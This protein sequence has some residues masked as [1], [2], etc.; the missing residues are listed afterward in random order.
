MCFSFP[1]SQQEAAGPSCM[2]SPPLSPESVLSPPPSV[3]STGS[4]VS[5]DPATPQKVGSVEL[6]WKQGRGEL[7]GKTLGIVLCGVC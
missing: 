3:A 1:V 4:C 6:L 2:A 7:V 5:S